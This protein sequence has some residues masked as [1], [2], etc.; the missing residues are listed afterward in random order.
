MKAI[1]FL[2]LLTSACATEET[3]NWKFK[4]P[5]ETLPY[6]YPPGQIEQPLD[7]DGYAIEDETPKRKTKLKQ[8]K[9]K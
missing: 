8:G 4:E 7:D 1:L 6:V 2:L 5:E 3:G 9:H